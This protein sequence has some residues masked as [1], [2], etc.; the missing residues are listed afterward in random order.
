[1]GQRRTVDTACSGEVP[2]V[3]PSAGSD[4]APKY[5]PQ[6]EN[7]TG[8]ASYGNLCSAKHVVHKWNDLE[9]RYLL[10]NWCPKYKKKT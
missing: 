10:K 3:N 7:L 1:V 6:K 5:N 4:R 9:N 2:R 8:C